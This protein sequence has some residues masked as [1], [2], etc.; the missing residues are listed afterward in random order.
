VGYEDY[1]SLTEEVL[2]QEVA[3]SA[4][5]SEEE[6]VQLELARETPRANWHWIDS[7]GVTV[8]PEGVVFTMDALSAER[9]QLVGDFSGWSLEGS[10]MERS[11]RFW[12]KVL[13]LPPGRYVYRYIVDGQWQSDPLNASVDPC[14]GGNN[15]VL[16]VEETPRRAL[17]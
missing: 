14:P 6:V 13:K 3:T 2:Q 4:T 15:S 16:V 8:T 12:R 17:N 5:A 7:P 10:D 11:G 9:V 1:H